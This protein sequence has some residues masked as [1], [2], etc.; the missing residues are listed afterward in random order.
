MW[1]RWVGE[2]ADY[3]F[4]SNR[5]RR[6][7]ITLLLMPP[8]K[9]VF[10]HVG[11]KISI[12][13]SYIFEANVCCS[14]NYHCWWFNV[15]EQPFMK[16]KKYRKPQGRRIVFRTDITARSPCHSVNICLELSIFFTIVPDGYLLSP[17]TR[18]PV[19]YYSGRHM[20]FYN[21]ILHWHSRG[22]PFSS[23]NSNQSL[24]LT[25]N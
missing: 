1:R 25:S 5:E 8:K 13:K 16:I 17:V 20:N 12:F 6:K 9:C 7:V 3:V 11:N 19:S 10:G 24:S 14:F 18:K 23:S 21:Q 4:L 22:S 15:W 2:I